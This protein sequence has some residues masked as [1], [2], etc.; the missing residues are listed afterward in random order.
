M[1]SWSSC[2][3]KAAEN[4]ADIKLC[5]DATEDVGRFAHVGAV[6]EVRKSEYDQQ[7]R[8]RQAAQSNPGQSA[9]MPASGLLC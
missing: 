5:L 9:A 4:G 8:L 2:F 1:Q 7:I 6:V 3:R